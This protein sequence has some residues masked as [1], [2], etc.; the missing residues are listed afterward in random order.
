MT[1]PMVRKISGG[2]YATVTAVP[3]NYIIDR[4]GI[5]RYA[6]ADAM[7]LDKLNEQLIPLLK[8]APAAAARPAGR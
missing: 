2:K 4:D 6:K 8:A 1:I 7:D 3:T 5:L